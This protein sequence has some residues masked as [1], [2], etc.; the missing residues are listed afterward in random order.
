MKH[1]FRLPFF[2]PHFMWLHSVTA[3]DKIDHVWEN[4]KCLQQDCHLFQLI[5]CPESGVLMFVISCL[6]TKRFFFLALYIF[7]QTSLT[8]WQ[9]SLLEHRN[10]PKICDK[11]TKM[12]YI[13]IYSSSRDKMIWLFVSLVKLQ[14]KN[15]TSSSFYLYIPTREM[16]YF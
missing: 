3:V 9:P 7:Y 5:L 16:Y 1:I 14:L 4:E 11:L 15:N 8:V 10:P 13:I 2:P 12:S 6:Q